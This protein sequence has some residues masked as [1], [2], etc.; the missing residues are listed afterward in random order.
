MWFP[1]IRK[2]GIRFNILVRTSGRPN[3]F[4]NCYQSIR[5]QRYRNYRLIISFDDNE[6]LA[7][8]KEYKI[9]R[10]VDLRYM[11]KTNAYDKQVSFFDE[12]IKRLRH[13]AK[14]NL[15]LNKMLCY[16]L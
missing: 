8:L 5:N 10:Y 4:R 14:Y 12:S 3:Y 7:Y 11:A 1:W 2:K 16:A 6:T 9:D 13:P 15:Y